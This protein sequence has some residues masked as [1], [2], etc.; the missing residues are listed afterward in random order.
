[1]VS[2]IDGLPKRSLKIYVV[3][4][5]FLGRHLKLFIISINSCSGCIF[6]YTGGINFK[7]KSVTSFLLMYPKEYKHQGDLILTIIHSENTN[8]HLYFLDDLD[9]PLFLLEV[10]ILF[11]FSHR[12]LSGHNILFYL[13]PYIN[14]IL[15]SNKINLIFLYS[16]DGAMYVLKIFTSIQYNNINV[17][18]FKAWTHYTFW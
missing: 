1:M 13:I 3:L 11:H 10:I 12:T 2:F 8:I 14:D 9:L 4:W 15:F 5:T 16:C 18:F 7:N 17:Q 6:Q